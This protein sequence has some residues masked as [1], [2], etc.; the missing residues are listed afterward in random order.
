M[1]E[2]AEGEVRPRVFFE[3]FPDLV[4]YV[5]D[6]PISGGGWTNVFMADSRPG[7]SSAVYLARRGRVIVDRDERTLEMV[8]EDGWRHTADDAGVYEV[9]QF[10]ELLLRLNPETV[11]PREGPPLGAREMSI[12]QL[13]VRAAELEGNGF[14][15]NSELFEIQKKFSIPVACLVFGL[16]GLAL[17]VSNRRDTKLASFV[18]GIGVILAYY[19]LLWLGQSPRA[20]TSRVA[21]AGGL[22]AQRRPGRAWRAPPRLAGSRRRSTD[23]DEPAAERPEI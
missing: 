18:I 13:R 2:R 23:T 9:F 1:A 20:G 6:I 12:A 4:L 21:L 7:Q 14:N 22:D 10:D 19:V 8:L 17:G 15:P 3:D 5:R 16:I 11:F